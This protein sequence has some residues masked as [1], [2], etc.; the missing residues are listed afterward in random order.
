MTYLGIC[1]YSLLLQILIIIANT[2]YYKYTS[3]VENEQQFTIH[4][5]IFSFGLLNSW[6]F[7]KSLI[8]F[9]V[10]VSCFLFKYLSETFLLIVAAYCATITTIH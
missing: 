7:S 8:L 10:L 6:S 1:K 4:N 2:H 9:F 3:L 5:D